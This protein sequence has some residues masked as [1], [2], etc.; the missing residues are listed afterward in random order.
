MTIVGRILGETGDNAFYMK[1]DEVVDGFHLSLAL[2]VRIGTD[3][4]IASLARLFLN[5]VEHSRIIV[6]H[7]IGHHHTN[8]SRGLLTKTLC[9]RVGTIV[10]TF[11]QGLHLLLHLG[12]DLWRTA[13]SPAYSCNAHSEFTRQ[14]LQRSSVYIVSHLSHE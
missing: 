6:G 3:H 11:G 12:T 13:Q 1:A 9:K 7:Q 8:H 10:Q 2:F 4:G 14:I 5:T